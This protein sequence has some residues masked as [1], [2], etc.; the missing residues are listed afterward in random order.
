MPR[1]IVHPEAEE[2]MAAAI[3]YFKSEARM[4]TADRFRERV[5]DAISAIESSPDGCPLVDDRHRRQRVF[6]FPYDV[7]FRADDRAIL[8]V[9]IAHHSR[10]V[11]YWAGRD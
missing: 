3:G 2:E 4:G 5:L 11:R 9:A 8:I 1:T 6:K 7:I 10:A